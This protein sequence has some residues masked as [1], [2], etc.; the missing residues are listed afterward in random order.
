MS[1]E[2]ELYHLTRFEDDTSRDAIR[3]LVE[4][5]K[6]VR[7][8]EVWF[9]LQRLFRRGERTTIHRFVAVVV[10]ANTHLSETAEQ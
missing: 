2:L 1:L 6:L 9:R 4:R 3:L 5:I 10:V 8:L 7:V